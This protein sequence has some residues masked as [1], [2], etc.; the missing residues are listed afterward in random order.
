MLQ[1]PESTGEF[2]R[3]S[4]RNYFGAYGWRWKTKEEDRER[5][6]DS[7]MGEGAMVERNGQNLLNALRSYLKEHDRVRLGELSLQ[8]RTSTENM[9]HLLAGWVEEGV[10]MHYAGVKRHSSN[11]P[12]GDTP[13]LIYGWT[14]G[15]GH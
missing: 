3:A 8:F 4:I 2:L 10:V 15:N 5:V 9:E 1:G 7:G 13:C 11:A 14:G 12:M 6:R